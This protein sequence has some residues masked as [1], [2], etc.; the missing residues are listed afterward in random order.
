MKG[1]L[2]GD[3]HYGLTVEDLDRSFEVDQA[4]TRIIDTAIEQE[5]DFVS[6][7]G[8][9]TDNNTPHPDHTAMLIHQ[10]NRLEDAEIP[11]FVLKGNHEAVVDA[12]RHWGLTPLERVGY[13]NVHFIKE[14]AVFDYDGLQ[15][16][17]LPH[18]T[19]GQ[20]VGSPHK[21][22]QEF[23]DAEA[24]R[25]LDEVEGKAIVISHYNING[26]M[27]GTEELMLRQ[28]DLQ[29]PA[30]L[31]RSPKVLKIF[32]SHIHT[33][34]ETHSGKVVMP[35]SPICTDFG[36]LTAK[37]FVL[38][39]FS[40]KG[41]KIERIETPMAPMMEVEFRLLRDD[42]LDEFK[43]AIEE[44]FTHLNEEMILKVRFTV[45]GERASQIEFGKLRSEFE[46][47]VKFLKLFDKT[48]IH[49]RAVR[50]VEQKPSLSPLEAVEQYIKTH[51]P[52]GAE[53]KLALA[54]RIIE[55]GSEATVGMS[56]TPFESDVAADDMIDEAVESIQEAA[57]DFVDDEEDDHD[58]P[59]LINPDS[60]D[61]EAIEI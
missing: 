45:A 25:L 55:E 27:A 54:K 41:V 26:A 46:K 12:R 56:L 19:R 20:V 47:R 48:L 18:A 31:L 29:L 53:R 51:K 11:T 13:E 33:P 1:I 7:G 39:E 34:Q 36:D 37:S 42:S 40:K 22:V 14:P 10:L 28:H 24:A 23:I 32:N 3:W 21:T 5:V 43:Q 8:D 60:A 16:L 57:A 9:L 59:D 49:K 15:L 38:A 58:I 4:V 6:I 50:D 44:S 35:G 30:I 17:F 52:E 61:L 2:T